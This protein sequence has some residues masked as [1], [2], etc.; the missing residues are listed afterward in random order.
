MNW[1]D[2]WKTIV[3]KRMI[4]FRMNEGV[5]PYEDIKA[6]QVHSGGKCLICKDFNPYMEEDGF[7]WSCSSDPRNKYK[8]EDIKESLVKMAS[9]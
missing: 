7:C 9:I 6:N 2:D 5:L 8:I 4:V 1:P 3:P